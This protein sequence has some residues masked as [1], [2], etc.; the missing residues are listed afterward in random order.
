MKKVKEY[1][2][3]HQQ[4][5]IFFEQSIEQSVLFGD[6][7]IQVAEDGRVWICVDNKA[8]IRFTPERIAKE[9]GP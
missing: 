2:E 5:N 9:Y 6:L 7:G 4:G 1:P 8:L 3:T